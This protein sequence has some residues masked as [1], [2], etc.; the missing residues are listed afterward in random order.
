MQTQTQIPR[1]SVI[2]TRIPIPQYIK[3]GRLI[4]SKGNNLKPIAD[5]TGTFIHVNTNTKPVQ[6][7]I[8][9]K[10]HCNASNLLPFENR[11]NEAKDQL[12]DLLK[13]LEEERNRNKFPL[14]KKENDIG[15][16]CSDNRHATLK[17]QKEIELRKERKYSKRET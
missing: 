3:I 8:K 17:Y 2:P 11:I 9:I 4:G 6:F 15:F 1:Y 14:K 13:E 10:R 16:L 5:G 12:N 7:E